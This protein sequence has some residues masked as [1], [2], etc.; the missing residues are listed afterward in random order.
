MISDLIADHLE[1]AR[2][3]RARALEEIRRLKSTVQPD[4]A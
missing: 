1:R 3:A 2:S 4:A